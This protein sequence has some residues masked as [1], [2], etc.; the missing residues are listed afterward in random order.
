[1]KLFPKL[2][3]TVSS[4]LIATTTGLSF[5]FYRSERTHIRQDVSQE[6]QLVLQN[7]VHITQESLLTNDDL[8][9]VKYTHWL[10]KWTPALRSAS[11]VGPEG[12]ILAHSEPSRIGHYLTESPRLAH[13][14]RILTAPVQLGSHVMATASL[15]FSEDYTEQAVRARLKELQSRLQNV[16]VWSLGIGVAVSFGLALSWTRPIEG[17]SRAAETVGKGKWT[18]HLGQLTRRN[19]ELGLL[20]KAFREMAKQLQQLDQL[21]E[22]FVSAVTH[23]LRSP[24]S[25][26]ESYLNLISHELA[27]GVTVADWETYIQ[28]LRLN[29]QRLSRFVNDLLDVAAIERGK[30]PLRP[31]TVDLSALAQDVLAL[32]RPKLEERHLNHDLQIC[33]DFPAVWADADKTRQVLIN[34]VSNAIKFTPDGGHIQISLERHSSK[35][36]VRCCVTDTGIGIAEEDQNKIF[37]KFEQVHSARTTVKGPKGTGLGLAISRSLIELQGGILEVKSQFGQGST[38]IFTLPIKEE[39]P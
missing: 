29:T 28:R 27:A 39:H 4:L 32:F 18:L 37:N 25:A 33:A 2:A 11:V 14:R 5:C 22:D 1:M 31:D 17:L 36:S 35:K 8:L 23:E 20:A 12:Q 9:L 21:K 13:E 24:L 3:L 30:I 19:D 26:M 16:A 34:L 15:A 10:R 7:L 38:F 6:Q